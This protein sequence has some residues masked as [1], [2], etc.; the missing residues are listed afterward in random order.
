[1]KYSTSLV[2][3]G[4]VNITRG[5]LTAQGGKPS[6]P[7]RAVSVVSE[8]QVFCTDSVEACGLIPPASRQRLS[9][10]GSRGPGTGIGGA[11][12][13]T[14]RFQGHSRTRQVKDY[15]GKESLSVIRAD[16][17]DSFSQQPRSLEL[18]SSSSALG[19]NLSLVRGRSWN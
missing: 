11:D 14:L 18:F 10:K 8:L 3:Q 9:S 17:E 5:G 7:P 2:Q 4:R 13:A 6:Y 16:L 1:M 15:L 19:E 12:T